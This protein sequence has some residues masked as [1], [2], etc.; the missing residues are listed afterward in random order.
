MKNIGFSK[1][2]DDSF[3]FEQLSDSIKNGQM[4][5]NINGVSEF[6]VSH[7]VFCA[8]QKMQKSAVVIV[9]DGVSARNILED[10]QF[11]YGDDAL[12]F[13]EKEL[14]FY[15]IDTAANDI[16]A[17]RLSALDK[18]NKNSVVVLTVSALLSQTVSLEA[19]NKHS[20]ELTVGQSYD[21]NLITKEFIS[22]GYY[23]EQ[24]VEGKGQFS[25][26]GGIV[27][28]Y[29]PNGE[30]PFRIEFFDDEID[31]IREFDAYTQRSV[32]KLTSIKVMPTSEVL[33]EDKQALI[34][35]LKGLLNTEDE[36]LISSLNHDIEK[37]ENFSRF[38]AIDKYLPLIYKEIPTIMDYFDEDLLVFL[39]EPAKI[40]ESAKNN[41][42]QINDTITTFIEKG[43]IPPVDG[44]WCFDYFDA[45]K[46]LTGK[47]LI[48]LSGLSNASPDYKPRQLIS[49][50]AK[51]QAVFHGKLEFF[52]D[53]VRHYKNN[54]YSIVILGGTPQKA[55]NIKK[56]LNDEDIE[57]QYV[58]DLLLP[59]RKGQ[60]MITHGELNRG[61]EYPLINTVII[62]DK[63]IF[64]RDKKHKRKTIPKNH[65]RL[66]SFTDLNVGDYVVHQNHGIGQFAGIKTMTVD[67][68]TSDYLQIKFSG[69][70]CLYI[71]TNQ[72][73]LIFKYVGRDGANIKL[74][75]L[76]TSAWQTTKQK[77]KQSCADM[78]DQLIRL[79][80]NRQN[81]EGVAF[82]K[83]QEWHANFAATFPYDE[84][85]DQLR[86]I[87]EVRIDM[88]T[89]RPMDRLLCGDVGYGKTEIALRAAFKAV[90]DGYQVAYLVP[91]T[92]LASQHYNTFCQRMKDFPIKIEMLSRFRS[93]KMQKQTVKNAKSGS[94]DI[95]IGTH[96]IIQKDIE[97]KKLGLLIIDEE[98]RFGVAHKERLKEIRNYVDVL[99]L[100]ATPIPRTLHMSMIGIRDMSVL[101]NPPKDRYPVS[102]YVLEHNMEIIKDAVLREVARG[103]QVYY[104]HNRVQTI[105]RVA[106]Q[107][108][109]FSPDLRVEIAHGKMSEHQ[110][111]DIMQKVLDFEVDV[112]VCTTIIETGLDI[113][114]I[115][116]II[117]EDADRMGLSQ[118][119]Q[120]RGRVGRSNRLAYAY[121]TYKKDKALSETAEKRL[122]AIRDFTEFG[123]GFKIALRDL[124]IRGAGNVVGAQQ[125]GH[126]DAVGYDM[127]C[128]LLG[129][130]VSA[131]K[132]EP[133]MQDIQT[134]VSIN[135]N[136]FIPKSYIPSENYRI[137]IYKKISGLENQQDAYDV[138]EEI[139]DRYGTVPQ[140]VANLIDIALIRVL[141]SNIGFEEVKQTEGGAMLLFAREAEMDIQII[142]KLIEKFSGK[143]LFSPSNK[144]HLVL[145]HK[146]PKLIDNIKNL[147][148][149]YKALKDADK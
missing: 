131:I 110:L 79:Y 144:P 78:A 117:I 139:E 36:V 104:L 30:N 26:R 124:E 88:E 74:N 10:L 105:E 81:I 136:A 43:L 6:V 145:R 65:E 52:Y 14:I 86:S 93:P 15:D 21:I 113:P 70:D 5:V 64:G 115:N 16:I 111:E 114:N 37:L 98:Q 75:K 143:I 47:K 148:Q 31:S 108:R 7:L 76:G 53:N 67:G 100:T 58:E 55:Q 146:G 54:N 56:A 87:D 95:I 85:D 107:I 82:S 45:I 89:P 80:A 41:E 135:Q 25:V 120:L 129:E 32:E 59:P 92:I 13:A 112:L 99:T 42:W 101:E 94:V 35:K 22:L 69:N 128:K 48:G 123:S 122:R 34:D 125:H 134:V 83:D 106:A 96:R 130:A 84:T 127:Y 23:R 46:K 63:E 97:F 8:C 109:T 12:L 40:S 51:S 71:P 28:F 90:M 3:E 60:I 103:G 18:L 132:G 61:V 9:P 17:S 50:T 141:A 39:Y 1:L 11:F 73:D 91:T 44:D 126:M 62:S 66:Q 116:T 2:L 72:L 33:I 121:L 4:P 142:S 20:F 57:A 118:L 29:P 68:A 149:D 119:Y 147:L 140:S 38:P 19:Y 49:F 24:M 27:D 138:Y 102:T 137:E 133:I 77:V